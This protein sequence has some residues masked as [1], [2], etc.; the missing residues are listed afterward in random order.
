MTT[1][2]KHAEDGLSARYMPKNVPKQGS[3]W[4]IEVSVCDPT[5]GKLVYHPDGTV[6]K[7]KI[8]MRDAQFEDSRPQPLYYP[9]DNPNPDL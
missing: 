2:L 5:T 4:G 8:R 1:H 7:I 6:R 9:K 3:N